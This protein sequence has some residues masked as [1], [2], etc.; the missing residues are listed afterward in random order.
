MNTGFWEFGLAALLGYGFMIV[1]SVWY[2]SSA[3]DLPPGLRKTRPEPRR[4]NEG[5]ST[6]GAILI[7]P[8]ISEESL[9]AKKESLVGV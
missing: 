7:T 6:N 9:V 4:M 3:T 2:F 8:Q 5:L 1:Y